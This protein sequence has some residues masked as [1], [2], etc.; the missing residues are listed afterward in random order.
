MRREIVAGESDRCEIN[1]GRAFCRARKC[2]E[3][4][5]DRRGKLGAC[6]ITN[7]LVN[8]AK[9]RNDRPRRIGELLYGVSNEGKRRAVERFADEVGCDIEDAIAQARLRAS[10]AVVQLIRVQHVQLPRQRDALRTAIAEPLHAGQR[11]ADR[12]AVVAMRFIRA[13]GQEDLGTLETRAAGAEA[14]PVPARPARS[15]KTTRIDAS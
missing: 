4:V 9:Q 5:G 12:V 10:S 3:R 1:P 15:F 7:R 13:R 14:D 6:E 2:T 8:I 11:D